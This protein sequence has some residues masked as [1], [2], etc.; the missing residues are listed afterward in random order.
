[1]HFSVASLLSLVALVS[2]APADLQVRAATNCGGVAYTAARV[3]AAANAACNYVQ[4]GGTAG[5]STYPHRYNNY[6]GF[7]FPVSGP[8][9]EFPILKSGK[10]YTGGA[11]PRPESQLV[12]LTC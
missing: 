11:S 7:D 5:S 10:V 4:N 12:C 3:Q 1:M 6:E 2:A 8:Y 9:N